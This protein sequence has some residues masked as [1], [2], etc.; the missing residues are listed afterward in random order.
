[1]KAVRFIIATVVCS[2]LFSTAGHAQL[3]RPKATITAFAERE[4]VAAGSPVRLALRVS[5][6]DGLHTQSNKPRDPNLIPTVLTVDAPTGITVEEIVFPPSTDLK[7][8]GQDQPLAVFERE[9]SIGVRVSLAS[10]L[11]PGEITVP[12]RLR[13]QAC[14][15][16]LC[17]APSTAQTAWTLHVGAAGSKVGSPQHDDVF[18]AIAFGRGEAPALTPAQTRA[19]AAAPLLATDL[20]ALE[21][22]EILGTTGGYLGQGEFL[23]F[24][25]NAENGVKEQGLFEGHGPL[26]IL[27]IVFLGGLALNLTP[28]VLPMIPINLAIIGAGTRAGSRGRGFL[29]GGVYGAAM[30]FVYGVL[31]VIVILTAGS[32]GTINASPWF[33]LGITA[34]FG[35]LALAM[36]DL[37]TIDFSGLSN[38]WSSRGSNRGSFVL[39]F[40]MGAVAALLAG[41]C[42]APVVIQVVLFS[43][44]LYATGTR[45]ALALPFFL[46]IG[47]AVP[48]PI[49]GAGLAALPKPGAWMVRV[50]Q[51]MGMLILATAVYYGY[52]SYTLFAN[53]WVDPSAVNSSVQEKLK[54]G[55]HASLSEGLAAARREQKPVLIDMWATWCKNCLTMDKT[56]LQDRAVTERIEPYVRIKV[57]AENPDE[58]PAKPLMKRFDA[59]GLPTYVILRPKRPRT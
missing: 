47:M 21:D 5:L 48:W 29:L 25:R 4:E 2:A 59:V 1:V 57:Q 51:A 3:T 44:S 52:E 40:S 39:A 17:Y 20:S 36:F 42:V 31:G 43:S 56:T 49:A 26:A 22:F 19:S 34:L 41:A 37:L 53:R 10:T 32:F 18:R 15:A 6:P 8:A 38:R 45:I 24:V 33:N 50:K 23:K 7:Q 54:A 11:S 16:T 27:L 28:C 30:A 14:D 58:P 12:A 55:W 9:F 13:Y 35:V 46:G